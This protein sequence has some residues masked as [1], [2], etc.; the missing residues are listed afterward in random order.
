MDWIGKLGILNT[1]KFRNAGFEVK[2]VQSVVRKEVKQIMTQLHALLC[3]SFKYLIPLLPE[4]K[5]KKRLSYS[6]KNKQTGRAPQNQSKTSLTGMP[7]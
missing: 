1:Q 3:R 4:K 5:K 6:R 2:T 7:P